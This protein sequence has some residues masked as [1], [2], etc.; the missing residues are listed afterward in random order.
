MKKTAWLIL[1][2]K[3]YEICFTM[4]TLAAV[5]R[6]IG[7]SV[8]S[9]FAGGVVHMVEGMSIDVTV[10]GLQYGLG[11]TEERAYEILDEAFE[12]GVNLDVV[13]GHIIKAIQATGL[14]GKPQE[15]AEKKAGK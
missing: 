4:R 10:A 5:E 3:Q 15:A 9:L 8:I 12:A 13:N 14:F 2:D 6:K 7:K 11:V 1:G